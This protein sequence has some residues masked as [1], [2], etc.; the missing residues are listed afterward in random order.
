MHQRRPSPRTHAGRRRRQGPRLLLHQ[1]DSDAAAGEEADGGKGAGASS[2]V[3]R[4][5]ELGG[6][7]GWEVV[8][9][10]G[11]A[12][13]ELDHLVGQQ[14][15]AAASEAASASASARPPA[16][17]GAAPPPEGRPVALALRD[18]V[19]VKDCLHPLLLLGVVVGVDGDGPV[20]APGGL[21]EE[22]A[23][24]PLRVAVATV[25]EDAQRHARADP[26]LE[27]ESGPQPLL[28]VCALVPHLLRC[29]PA[30]Q[31]AHHPQRGLAQRG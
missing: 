14:L 4:G 24:E 16:A 3:R 13:G 10:P 2:R 8:E 30:G 11:P 6:C 9:E 26:P 15:L 21:V 17:L 20:V 12:G 31:R 29:H 7:A 1:A 5:E 19:V 27:A 22:V 28:R 25:G 23:E 18:V